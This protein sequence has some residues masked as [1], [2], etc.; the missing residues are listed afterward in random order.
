M[1]TDAIDP[2]NLQAIESSGL[3]ILS[4]GWTLDMEQL[5][6]ILI[7]NG[8]QCQLHKFHDFN[9][10]FFI[11]KIIIRLSKWFETEDGARA[12]FTKLSVA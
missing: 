1:T 6:N 8:F 9:A 12:F 7:W 10:V 2:Y 5:P 11:T 3:L 4:N